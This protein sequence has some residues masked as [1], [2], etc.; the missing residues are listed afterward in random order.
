[1]GNSSNETIKPR[2]EPSQ[3]R[4][5]ARVNRILDAAAELLVEGGLRHVTTHRVAERAAVNVASIYQ[6]YP[7]KYA[8]LAALGQRYVDKFRDIAYQYR[9]V[10]FSAMPLD[11]IVDT[12]ADVLFSDPVFPILWLNNMVTPE[13]AFSDELATDQAISLMLPV[14]EDWL[15]DITP[16]RRQLVA[17]TLV[18]VAKPLMFAASQ[19]QGEQRQAY[20]HELKELARGY[21]D[22]AA[23]TP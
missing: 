4:S 10:E 3:D 1:M 21:L 7:N 15:P 19:T 2:R 20:L 23:A 16:E 17:E 8:L 13:L 9:D 5:R 11:E 12:V 14:L 18:L 6:F 22:R